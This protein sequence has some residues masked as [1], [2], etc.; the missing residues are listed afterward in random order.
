MAPPYDGRV[1]DARR[2]PRITWPTVATLAVAGVAAW[3]LTRASPLAVA[4]AVVAGWVILKLGFAVLGGLATQPPEP[5]PPGELR[6]V[7][8]LYRCSLC[9]TEVRMTTA[10]AEDPE[11]PRH[12]MEDMDLVSVSD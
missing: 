3:L 12:C 8:L 5:P 10:N 7:R 4:L 9:G 6:K 11:P 1:A 2:R